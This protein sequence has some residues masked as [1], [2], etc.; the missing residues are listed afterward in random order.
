MNMM[1]GFVAAVL[2]STAM[3]QHT[4]NKPVVIV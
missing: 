2:S 1:F 4:S 3:Q